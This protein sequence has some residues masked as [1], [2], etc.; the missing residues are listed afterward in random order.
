MKIY[1]LIFFIISALFLYSDIGES[2]HHADTYY[3]LGIGE[4]GDMEAFSNA[5]AYLEKAESRLEKAGID[6]EKV[7]LFKQKIITLREDILIQ[8]DMAHDTFFGVFPLNRVLGSTVFIDAA[9]NG[10][11]EFI[12]DPDV[13]AVC[14]GAELVIDAMNSS[15]KYSPQYGIVINSNPPN[16]ALENEVRYIFNRDSRFFVHTSQ[17]IASALTPDELKKYTAN[18]IDNELMSHLLKKMNNPYLAKIT[19]N[20]VDIV[21]G[22]YFF[23]LETDLFWDK[24]VIPKFKV[25]EMTFCRD[26][27]E[28][29]APIW[30]INTAFFLLALLIFLVFYKSHDDNKLKNWF[31]PLLAF[32]WGRMLPWLIEPLLLTIRPEPETLVK[33]SFW[34]LIVYGI[35]IICG[36]MLAWYLI[37][38]RS[39]ALYKALDPDGWADIALICVSLGLS[40]H[41]GEKI[42]LYDTSL[43]A[44][45]IM[46]TLI[47]GSIGYILGSVLDNTKYSS[48]WFILFVLLISG[49]LGLVITG[50][51]L[52][53]MSGLLLLSLVITLI[54]YLRAKNGNIVELPG[55]IKPETHIL[56]NI[57]TKPQYQ[58]FPFFKECYEKVSHFESGSL[59]RVLLAGP[60]GRGKTATAEA[61]ISKLKNSF[62]DNIIILKG[63]CPDQNNHLNPYA[64]LQQALGKISSINFNSVNQDNSDINAVF[65]NLMGTIIPFSSLLIPNDGDS[66]GLQSRDQLNNLIYN[67]LVKICQDSKIILFLDD[68][69]W[70]DDAT[71]DFLVFL[72]RKMNDDNQLTML[73][74]LTSRVEEVYAEIGLD[75]EDIVMIKP[76][77]DIEKEL[78]LS[79]GL[80]FDT[81]LSHELLVRFGNNDEQEGEMFFLLSILG[82]LAREGTFIKSESGY[83]LSSKYKSVNQLP[84]P[85]SFTDSVMERLSRI[86]GKKIIVECAACIGL[87]FEVEVLAKSLE[88]TR[89]ETICALNE[90][91]AETDFVYDVGEFDDVY[92][93]SSSAVLEVLRTNLSVFDFGPLNPQVPQI[94]REYHARLATVLMSTENSPVFAIANHFYAAGKLHIEKAI[95]YC[96]K[97]AQSAVDFF[98]YENAQKY[99]AMAKECAEITGK[100]QELAGAFLQLEI[101]KSLIINDRQEEI[102][103]KAI[104]YVETHNNIDERLKLMI[105]KC[106]YN[107]GAANHVQKYFTRAVEIASQVA[108]TTKDEFIKAESNHILAISLSPNRREE[109]IGIL[110]NTYSSL[111]KMDSS[112]R[113]KELLSRIGNSLA[114]KLTYGNNEEKIQAEELFR[115]SIKIKEE[116]MDKPG[117]ARSWGGLGRLYLENNDALAAKECFENDLTLC[118]QIGDIGG[119]VKMYSFIAEC[120]CREGNFT[121]ASISYEKSFRS[122]E[123]I[124]DQLFAA[125]GLII[126]GLKSQTIN[127]YEDYAKFLIKHRQK[128]ISI[129]SGFFDEIIK[130]RKENSNVPQWLFDL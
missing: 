15:Q 115:H 87:Q 90:I 101:S 80:G 32:L 36:T 21:E 111:Q 49:L 2:I 61:L 123:D 65:D 68:V 86:P 62:A 82:E 91:E 130:L 100:V 69:Q 89:L 63:E 85:D 38:K 113:T 34:W 94:I 75:I 31:I 1:L 8:Q 42:M 4:H 40:A 22:I 106:L 23:I 28:A 77:Q 47:I 71:K 114:E 53:A 10:S 127:N 45:V 78:I 120:Q 43:I 26:R 107:A 74:L 18:E 67:T 108:N 12:D 112:I 102:A 121:E 27:R 60:S 44:V 25:A 16:P 6:D 76:L 54:A 72:N 64:P 70:I 9:A 95:E 93:F 122:A 56:A 126:V 24:E 14:N 98:Q 88:M 17:E 116:L 79:N 117:L 46:E 129:W 118:R 11:Y 41:F 19:I 3:W 92:A 110:K 84:I 103:D 37:S 13:I 81:A 119:K 58:E 20:Q 29:F 99:L 83:I 104:Q 51:Q 33:I 55:S 50:I 7:K 105:C 39:R 30:I 66:N 97:A 5:L 52:W 109:I 48:N 128:A 124:E 57:M 35:V 59:S 125:R 73:L 96:L